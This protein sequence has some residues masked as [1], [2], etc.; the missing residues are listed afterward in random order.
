MSVE[1]IVHQDLFGKTEYLRI[2]TDGLNIATTTAKEINSWDTEI[3]VIDA[4]K[5][6]QHRHIAAVWLDGSERVEYNRILVI[7]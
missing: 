7:N 5:A 1:Y 2:L 6:N 3:D 4:G